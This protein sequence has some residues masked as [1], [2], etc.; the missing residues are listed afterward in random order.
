LLSTDADTDTLQER[1]WRSLTDRSK[2][3]DAA[4]ATN[5]SGGGADQLQCGSGCL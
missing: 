1:T 3:S 2:A 4:A 5:N